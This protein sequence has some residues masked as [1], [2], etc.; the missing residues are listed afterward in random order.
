MSTFPANILLKED[1]VGYEKKKKTRAG[2]AEKGLSLHEW[3]F[4]RGDTLS[5]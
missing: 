5:A 1:R 3:L 4:S 2:G